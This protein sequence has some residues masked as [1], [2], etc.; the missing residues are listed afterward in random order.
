MKAALAKHARRYSKRIENQ[1][2]FIQDAWLR[3]AKQQSDM[4]EGYYS[5]QGRKAMHASYMRRWKRKSVHQNSTQKVNGISR[6]GIHI[7]RAIYLGRGRYL[8][9]K[10]DIEDK[11]DES[12]S[13]TSWY[14]VDEWKNYVKV[15]DAGVNMYRWYPI[16]HCPHP[17]EI[18][19]PVTKEDSEKWQSHAIIIDPNWH[20]PKR[21][22]RNIAPKPDLWGA[23]SMLDRDLAVY[24]Y[25]KS[26]WLNHLE[27]RPECSG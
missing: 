7:P 9:Q 11:V 27:I 16:D 6:E 3:I 24:E 19:E 1:E 8:C 2:E 21:Q 15:W 10:A 4:I 18:Q 17:V 25:K 14:H 5:E 12:L 22:K 26:R 23:R 13:G 20:G